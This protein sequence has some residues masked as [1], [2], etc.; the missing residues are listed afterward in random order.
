MRTFDD[1]IFEGSAAASGLEDVAR[2]GD[3]LFELRAARKITTLICAHQ[4]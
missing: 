3:A 4:A 2:G 1:V